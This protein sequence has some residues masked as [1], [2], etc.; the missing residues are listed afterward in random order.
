MA[1]KKLAFDNIGYNLPSD[2]IFLI[3]TR[4]P[5]KS[6]LYFKS[7]CKAWNVMIPDNEFRRIHRSQSKALGREKLLFHKCYTNEF[8]FRDLKTSQLVTIAKEV[9][10]PE[11]FRKTSLVL[12]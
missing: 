5:V 10:P 1:K 12:M 2:I 7:I 8:E 4:V 3:L 6:L 9:S 11:K